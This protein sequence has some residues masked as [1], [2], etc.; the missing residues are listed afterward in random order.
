MGYGGVKNILI[1]D[2]PDSC[3]SWAKEGGISILFTNQ[4][5]Y[6]YATIGSFNKDNKGNIIVAHSF[7]ELL[8]FISKITKR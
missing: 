1:D 6:R 3:I 8:Q 4:R 7:N 2:N 5:K